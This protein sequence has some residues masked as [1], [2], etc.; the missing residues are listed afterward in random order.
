MTQVKFNRRPLYNGFSHL[1]DDFF[2]DLPVLF[3]R[4]NGSVPVNINESE[5]G[6]TVDIFAP[7]FEKS[8]FKVSA[9]KDLLTISATRSE[10]TKKENGKE[11]RKEFHLNSFTRTFTLDDKLNADGIEA[12]Y[13]NGVLTLNIPRKEEVKPTSKLISIQ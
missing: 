10:E 6:Y 2:S 5:N 11:L 8:D 1:V 7:G 9:E 13:V 3:N 12:K 4:A